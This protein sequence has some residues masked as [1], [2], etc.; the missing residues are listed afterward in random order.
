[1]AGALRCALFVLL[2]GC[3]SKSAPSGEPKADA[4]PAGV[5]FR[6]DVMPLVQ[7]WCATAGCH[8][9]A[10][11]TN[12]WTDFSTPVN[13][14][15]RWVDGPGFDFCTDTA[16]T[17]EQRTIVVPR[18]PELSFLIDK[19]S[20]TRETPCKDNHAPRMPPPPRP[21]LDPSQIDMIASWIRDG[22]PDN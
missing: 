16:D 10:V 8:D 21:P 6:T 9:R 4:G 13:T 20:S 19:I 15:A 14:Y 22:A 3:A 1:M 12:H 2:V 7:S 5:S 17:Y 11:T 18:Y